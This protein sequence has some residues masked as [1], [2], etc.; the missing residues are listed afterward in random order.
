M[1]ET[2]DITITL[3]FLLGLVLIAIG[4]GFVYI[5]SVEKELAE[6]LHENAKLKIDLLKCY[7]QS[8]Y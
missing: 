5:R 2:L 7:S 3:Y 8:L 1:T 6:A 4:V